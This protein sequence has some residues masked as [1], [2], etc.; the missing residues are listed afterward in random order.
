LIGDLTSHT[1]SLITMN[2]T[3]S[4]PLGRWN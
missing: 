1:I 4:H 3:I 2:G